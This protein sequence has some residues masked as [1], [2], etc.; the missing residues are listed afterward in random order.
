LL[1]FIFLVLFEFV[2]NVLFNT[3]VYNI[4][5][6]SSYLLIVQLYDIYVI[7]VYVISIMARTWFAFG[8]PFKTGVAW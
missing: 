5:K 1:S 8:L 6:Y 7:I 3:M 2:N 4:V